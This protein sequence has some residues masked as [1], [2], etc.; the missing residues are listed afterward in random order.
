[1]PQKP[2]SDPVTHDWCADSNRK[3]CGNRHKAESQPVTRPDPEVGQVWRT[4]EGDVYVLFRDSLLKGFRRFY[5]H[6][7]MS[8]KSDPINLLV[9]QSCTY[10][11]QFAGFKVKETT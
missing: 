7:F 11:G 10:V 5:V 9:Q 8:V 2:P 4:V 6:G 1:M 3:T